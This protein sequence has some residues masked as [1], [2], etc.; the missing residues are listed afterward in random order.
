[1]KESIKKYVLINSWLPIFYFIFGAFIFVG[2]TS[3]TNH[4]LVSISDYLLL[5]S[6]LIL[7]VTGIWQITKG[8]RYYGV[9]Q[10]GVLLFG[11]SGLAFIVTFISLFGADTDTFADNLIIP[12]NI[13]IGYPVDLQM[14]ENFEG[15]RPDS[16][17]LKNGE[18][19]FQLYNSFQGGLYEYDIWIGSDKSGVLFLK[20][21][22]VTQEV[23]LSKSTLKE[24]SAIH[25]EST[26]GKIQKFGT[27]AP[28]TIYEGDWGK[29]Y[30]ARFEVWFKA[31][32]QN[33][34]I[35][36]FEKNFIIEG[37]MR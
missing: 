26:N 14:D 24:S 37:W 16:I 17:S 5:S 15:I 33:E 3:S 27:N 9:L 11:I 35:K 4:L 7:L 13:E 22:E 28:F 20:A 21:F 1:M 34:E 2:L 29:P 23:Q 10:L 6:A 31:D 12:E 25:I 8:N 32:N 30:G 19:K 18:P 36:L